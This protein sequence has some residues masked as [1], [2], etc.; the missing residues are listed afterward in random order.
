MVDEMCFAAVCPR[1]FIA[2]LPTL[3][4][5]LLLQACQLPSTAGNTLTMDK[6]FLRPY[7]K[8]PELPL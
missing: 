1:Q 3:A 2:Q 5:L 8:S 4:L 7:F 6:C